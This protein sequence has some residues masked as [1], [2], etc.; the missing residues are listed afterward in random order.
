[1]KKIFLLV[2]AL[3]ISGCDNSKLS[4]WEQGYEDGLRG[5][6]TTPDWDNVDYANGYKKG[7]QRRKE[8]MK[9]PPHRQP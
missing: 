8:G 4:D 3:L 1:M 7:S 9:L 5:R 2:T 6:V